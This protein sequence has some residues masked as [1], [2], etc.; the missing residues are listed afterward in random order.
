MK[1][2]LRQEKT[3]GKNENCINK[4]DKQQTNNTKILNIKADVLAKL[5]CDRSRSN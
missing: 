1:K 2:P 3:Q 4:K 5:D